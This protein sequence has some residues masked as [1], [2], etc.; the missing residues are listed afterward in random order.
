MHYNVVAPY[1]ERTK[2]FIHIPEEEA[3]VDK[4]KLES[5]QRLEASRSS[6]INR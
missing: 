1:E 3:L 2:T 6:S 4:S 5:P